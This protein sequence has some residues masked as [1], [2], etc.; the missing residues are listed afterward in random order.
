M[1]LLQTVVSVTDSLTALS[2][3]DSTYNSC[4]MSDQCYF[5]QCDH[6]LTIYHTIAE[7]FIHFHCKRFVLKPLQ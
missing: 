5:I 6:F 3:R 4:V 2:L 7:M 1:D